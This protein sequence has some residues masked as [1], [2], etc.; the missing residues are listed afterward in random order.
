MILVP[1]ALLLHLLEQTVD[2]LG[3]SDHIC[4][5]T[6]KSVSTPLISHQ[7]PSLPLF[8]S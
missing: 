4:M 5:L 1:F 6:S 3:I 8:V 2:F 7:N